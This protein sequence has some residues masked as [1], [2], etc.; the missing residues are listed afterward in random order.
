MKY[1]MIISDYDG[2]LATEGGIIPQ[3]TCDKIVE[4]KKAGGKF[5][6]CTGRATPSAEDTLKTLPIDIDATLTFQGADIKVNGNFVKKAGIPVQT[7]VPILEELLTV[8]KEFC[9]YT[10]ECLYYNC[11]GYPPMEYY[12][13]FFPRKQ[14]Y[15]TDILGQL[16]SLSGYVKKMNVMKTPDENTDKVVEI[17]SKYTDI[18]NFNS[19]ASIIIEVINKTCTKYTA[20]KFIAEHFGINEDQVITIGDSTNDLALL[21]FGFPIAVASGSDLLKQK[22]KYI[23]PSIDKLPVKH[24]I[25]MVLEGKDFN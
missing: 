23:A 14:A 11:E 20:S 15:V 18:I 12:K 13:R 22:A 17:L 4:Y 6:L 10:D 25:E 3:Q 9:F 1:K 24:V 21:D 8:K 16:K 5:V 2:T 7:L 19:G